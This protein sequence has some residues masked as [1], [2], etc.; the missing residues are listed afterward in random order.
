[1]TAAPSAPD[2][3]GRHTLKIAECYANEAPR[4]YRTKVLLQEVAPIGLLEDPWDDLPI[5]T[6]R[7]FLMRSDECSAK[8]LWSVC[9][10]MVVIAINRLFKYDDPLDARLPLT[11]LLS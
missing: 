11:V 10:A 6:R 3:P 4:L 5:E 1:M 9:C 2:L 8:P 7:T